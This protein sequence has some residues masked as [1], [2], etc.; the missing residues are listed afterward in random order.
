MD[1][2]GVP[3]LRDELDQRGDGVELLGSSQGVNDY[4]GSSFRILTTTVSA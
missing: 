4:S 3:P 1:F 2:G